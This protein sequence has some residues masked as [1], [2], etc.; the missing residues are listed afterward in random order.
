MAPGGGYANHSFFGVEVK[1]TSIRTYKFF[2]AIGNIST[3]DYC[4]NL[5]YLTKLV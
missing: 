5:K 3:Y 2:I 1:T 4:R